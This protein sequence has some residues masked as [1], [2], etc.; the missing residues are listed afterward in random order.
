MTVVSFGRFQN[1]SLRQ[2]VKFCPNF[3]LQRFPNSVW[4]YVAI[5]ETRTGRACANDKWHSFGENNTAFVLLHPRN[6]RGA[7]ELL[8]ILNGYIWERRHDVY[9][10]LTA[11]LLN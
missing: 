5:A 6:G 9:D 10:C 2:L 7:T 4:Q 3:T 11:T 8:H 1:S